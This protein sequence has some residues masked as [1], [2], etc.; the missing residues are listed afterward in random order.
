MS[1]SSPQNNKQSDH[2]TTGKEADQG[3]LRR[4]GEDMDTAEKKQQKRK[5][6]ESFQAE[7]RE[8]GGND[9]DEDFER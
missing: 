9:D 4:S 8:E 7:E 3:L 5:R 2:R 1:L 6:E